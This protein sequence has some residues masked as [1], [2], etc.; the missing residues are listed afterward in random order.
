MLSLLQFAEITDSVETIVDGKHRMTVGLGQR[1]V[2]NH[3]K[4][5]NR[6]KTRLNGY[7]LATAVIFL[8]CHQ[9]TADREGTRR[10]P[11]TARGI[12][13][14]ALDAPNAV[15]I[16]EPYGTLPRF[17]TRILTSCFQDLSPPA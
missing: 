1:E 12:F 4:H 16:Q 2:R 11:V 17:F 3:Q 13:D 6:F 14:V 10:A 5:P 9:I 7:E 8:C 15:F